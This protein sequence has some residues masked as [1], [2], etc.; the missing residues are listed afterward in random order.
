LALR[1]S[2][3]RSG[4]PPNNDIVLDEPNVSW[5]HA[6]LRPGEPPTLRD[7]GSR[8]GVRLGNQ[9]LQA[10]PDITD[11]RTQ[12]SLRGEQSSDAALAGD[13]NRGGPIV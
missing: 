8:N 10:R 5:R 1:R 9:L 2:V 13:P 12:L 11:P 6:E 4:R 7:N 3:I